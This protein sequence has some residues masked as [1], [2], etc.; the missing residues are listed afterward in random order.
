MLSF[1]NLYSIVNWLVLLLLLLLNVES[2]FSCNL[3]MALVQTES[4]W[5]TFI[6]NARIADIAVC[7]T[8]D[9][10]LWLM[11]LQDLHYLNWIK[12]LLL[13]FVL[14]LLSR[15]LNAIKNYNTVTNIASQAIAPS[16]KASVSAILVNF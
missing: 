2:F 10:Y 7:T 3:N 9:K 8:Y 5:I 11:V 15:L 13:N 14:L 1:R 4:E 6:Q 12:K 16:A